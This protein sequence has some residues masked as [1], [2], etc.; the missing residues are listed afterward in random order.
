MLTS[1][2][3]PAEYPTVNAKAYQADPEPYQYAIHNGGGIAL[4]E[5]NGSRTYLLADWHLRQLHETAAAA[6]H[7]KE[8]GEPG[9]STRID[10][11]LTVAK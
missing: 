5:P 2:E 1:P 7:Q 4:R 10:V 9:A 6:E 8:N 11:R 3:S